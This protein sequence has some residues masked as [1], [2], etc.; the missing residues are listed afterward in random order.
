VRGVRALVAKGTLHAVTPAEYVLD[1]RRAT[2]Y[3]LATY[4][5]RS[6]VINYRLFL[7]KQIAIQREAIERWRRWFVALVIGG[8]G[9][10]IAGQLVAI[11]GVPGNEMMKLAGAFVG[12]V[13]VFPYQQITP[14]EERIATYTILLQ[15]VGAYDGLEPEEQTH[16]RLLI[17][18]AMKETFKR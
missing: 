11:I 18:D 8:I 5:S 17:D 1:S 16:L 13:S 4:T 10:F 15:A 2:R 12:V 3:S 14:R 6:A 7:E 9:V